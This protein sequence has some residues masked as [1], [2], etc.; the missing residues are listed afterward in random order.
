MCLRTFFSFLIILFI[1]CLKLFINAGTN[2]STYVPNLAQK[3]E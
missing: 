1:P 2:N 3:M